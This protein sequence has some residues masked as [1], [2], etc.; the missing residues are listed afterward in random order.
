MLKYL[1]ELT[2]TSGRFHFHPSVLAKPSFAETLDPLKFT[3]LGGF[4]RIS[5]KFQNWVVL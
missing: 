5:E 3:R 4:A 2:E 1:P